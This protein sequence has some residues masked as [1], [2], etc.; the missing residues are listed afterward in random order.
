MGQK[1]Y[2]LQR[3]S[4]IV[5]PKACYVCHVGNSAPPR[6]RIV[7]MSRAER[8]FSAPL[9]VLTSEGG[10]R[11]GLMRNLNFEFASSHLMFRPRLLA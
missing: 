6:R 11:S 7:N 3:R 1:L 8:P 2:E 4:W 9:P 5:H 10:G